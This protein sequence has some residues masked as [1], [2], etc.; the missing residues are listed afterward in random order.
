MAVYDIEICT[1]CVYTAGGGVW[2]VALPEPAPLAWVDPGEQVV[3]PDELTEPYFSK[4]K[5]DAC[6]QPLAGDRY[7]AEL[8]TEDDLDV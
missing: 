4:K 8:W 6:G 1:D 7:D 2:E 5:C 3:L